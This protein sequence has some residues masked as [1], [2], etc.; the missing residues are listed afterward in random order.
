MSELSRLS[1]VPAS[2]IYSWEK[3]TFTPQVD[4]LAAVMKVLGNPVESVIAIPAGDRFPGDW[5]VLRGLTQPQLAAEAEMSASALQR[6]ESGE[7]APTDAQ[8]AV[9]SRLLDTDKVEYRAAWLRAKERPPG[10]PV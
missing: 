2:T 9:L 6:I 8:A 10:T 7:T 5:R 1:G 4:K 3:R